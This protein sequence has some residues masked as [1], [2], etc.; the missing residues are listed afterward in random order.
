MVVNY[1]VVIHRSRR[2]A[3]TANSSFGSTLGCV[4]IALRILLGGLIVA[5]VAVAAVPVFAILDLIDGGTGWGLCPN[6]L[7]DCETSYFSGLELA[8][9]LTLALFVLLGLIAVCNKAIK[10][11]Q[12]RSAHNSRTAVTR[13]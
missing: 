11:V 12:S 2:G 13:R 4:L 6:G 10:Y 8:A 7:S 9:L 1:A 3:V 5:V